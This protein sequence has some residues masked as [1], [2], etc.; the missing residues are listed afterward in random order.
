MA[1]YQ[2]IINLAL[3]RSLFYPSSEI[4]ANAPAG[5]YSYGPYGVEIRRKIVDLWRKMILKKEGMLEIDGSICMPADVFKSSRHLTD[6]TDPITDC[7]KCKNTFRADQLLTERTGKEYKE[8]MSDKKLTSAMQKYGVKCPKC[9]GELMP[10]KR[11]SLMVKA[12]VGVAKKADVYLRPETCQSIFT[13]FIRMFRTMRMKLP[14][15]I[16]QYG[17]S[18]RNEISPRQT[19][20]RQVEF[21][22]MEAEVFFNPKKIDEI[23]NFDEVKKVK[24]NIQLDNEDKPKVMTVSDLIKKKIVSGKL[25]AYYLARTQQLYEAYGFKL[26]DTRFRQLDDEERAFYAKEG[27]DFEVKTSIGWLELIANNYRTDYDLKGH[28]EGSKKDLKVV[29]DDSGE[30]FIPHVWEISMGTDRVFYAILENAYRKDTKRIWLS[31]PNEIAPMQIAV[32]P[33]L[34]NKPKLVAR[35]KE[36]MELLSSFDAFYD[37]SGSIG[38]RYARMDE[39]GVPYCVTIDFDTLEDE[40]VT[41]RERDSMKQKRVKV[42][43]LKDHFCDLFSS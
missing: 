36:V 23:E 22:Q 1:E 15:G 25:I 14:Q 13:E 8:S 6:F 19:L 35:A 30:K 10:V 29:D 39:V 43:E 28:I 34:S 40:T 31:L 7:T 18:Y 11:S 4:Y 27:W 37:A 3:R 24:L 32:F 16:A 42:S 33:L 20:L 21:Y 5:F 12:N 26:K 2:D 17:K 9:K 41:L 38:K